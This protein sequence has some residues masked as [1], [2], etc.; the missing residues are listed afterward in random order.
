MST[1]TNGRVSYGIVFEEGYKFPWDSIKYD[2]EV[3][4]WWA[5]EVL[6]YKKKKG[7]WFDEEGYWLN[8]ACVEE[9]K[10]QIIVFNKF[11]EENPPPIEL[12]NC[13]SLGYPMYIIAVPSSVREARRGF[14]Q[15]FDPSEL[16][17]TE[18]ERNA[19]I[20]FCKTHCEVTELDGEELNQ[21]LPPLEPKWY[22]SSY[23][24]TYE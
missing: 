12:I 13:Q 10:E 23:W 20:E 4:N 3:E 1:S 7:N 18:G 22:L 2:G 24:S 14:P 21:E 6:G 8:D 17:V 5:V 19:L 16:M 15:S 9:C 11:K